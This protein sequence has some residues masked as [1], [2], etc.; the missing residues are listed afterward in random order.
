MAEYIVELKNPSDVKRITA[1]Y[2]QLD[3]EGQG[4]FDFYVVG[5]DANDGK[6]ILTVTIRSDDVRSM[7]RVEASKSL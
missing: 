4:W 2:W 6:D 1:D 3:P 5:T 7:T